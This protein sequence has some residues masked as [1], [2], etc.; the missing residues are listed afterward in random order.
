MSN[1]FWDGEQMAYGNGDGV[2]FREFTR[3]LD[4]IGHELT[5]GVVSFTSNLKYFGQS[6]ALNEHFADVFGILV[7]QWKNDGVLGARGQ[8]AIG[9]KAGRSKRVDR[10]VGLEAIAV[11]SVD[12]VALVP[13]LAAT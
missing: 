12:R 8:P 10:L 9:R 1:A 11:P 7:R 13:Q 5:H 2:I 3:S 6:G 4:V